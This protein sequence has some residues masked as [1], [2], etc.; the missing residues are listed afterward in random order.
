MYGSGQNL[1]AIMNDR[2][3]QIHLH[4]NVTARKMIQGAQ[5]SVW[6]C[7]NVRMDQ[8]LGQAILSD[9]RG[10]VQMKWNII[11]LHCSKP[12]ERVSRS[13]RLEVL[14][15]WQNTQHPSPVRPRRNY[16]F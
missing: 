16:I 1:L 2:R 14:K 15:T 3:V 4:W 7:L 10:G 12:F 5:S 13:K 9:G 8:N 6:R 11:V